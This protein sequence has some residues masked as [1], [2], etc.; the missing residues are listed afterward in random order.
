[1]TANTPTAT[2]PT[3]ARPGGVVKRSSQD[4]QPRGA[5]RLSQGLK[6]SPANGRIGQQFFQRL[7]IGQGI[8]ELLVLERGGIEVLTFFSRERI[9]GKSA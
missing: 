9:G 7:F 4:R 5:V 2:P 8:E 3:Q 1:M 6:Q